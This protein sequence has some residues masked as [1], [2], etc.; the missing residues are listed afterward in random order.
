MVAPGV[1]PARVGQLNVASPC[2]VMLDRPKTPANVGTVFRSALA[3]G[4]RTVILCAPRW[5]LDRAPLDDLKT[6]PSNAY[7]HLDVRL[8]DTLEAGL[9]LAPAHDVVVVERGLNTPTFLDAFTHP[10][11][12]VYIFGPE[13]SGVAVRSIPPMRPYVPVEIRG[14]R[15]LAHPLQGCLNLATAVSIVLYDRAA[16]LRRCA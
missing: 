12:C 6:D 2:V 9:A 4:A 3:L 13:D 11:R 8:V 10:E 16:Q 7:R 15:A 1:L 5:P 14:A